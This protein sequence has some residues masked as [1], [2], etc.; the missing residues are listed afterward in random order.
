MKIWPGGEACEYT[1]LGHLDCYLVLWDKEA[2]LQKFNVQG[3]GGKDVEVA[4][5][6]VHYTT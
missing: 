4:N 6:S 5:W 3:R 2:N 1:R